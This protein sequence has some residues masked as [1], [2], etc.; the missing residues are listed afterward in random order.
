MSQSGKVKIRSHLFKFSQFQNWKSFGSTQ[1]Y[2]TK[3]VGQTPLIFL[4]VTLTIEK[5]S[6]PEAHF[7]LSYIY[8]THIIKS[9]LLKLS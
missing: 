5:E 8:S 4:Y 1:A 7:R 6:Q 9:D 3:Y 2:F